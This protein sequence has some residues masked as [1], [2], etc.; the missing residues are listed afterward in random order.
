MASEYAPID[1]GNDNT[2]DLAELAEEVRRTNRAR[3]LR[4]AG[5]DIAVLMPATK[6]KSS[7][8]GG[9]PVTE[10]DPIFQAIG[11]GHSGT[12]DISSNKHKYLA[13]AYASKPFTMIEI[14]RTTG[15]SN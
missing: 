2:P 3:L 15:L 7:R 4:R 8:T 14:L 5:E 9:K 1:L 13:E 11:I 6:K 12:G 10:D